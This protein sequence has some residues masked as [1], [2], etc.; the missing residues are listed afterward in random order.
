MNESFE[1]LFF[2]LWPGQQVRQ[3]LSKT[4]AGVTELDGQGRVMNPANLHMTLHFLGNIPVQRVACFIENAQKIE[5]PCFELEINQLGYFDRPKISWLGPVEIP[6]ALLGLHKLLGENIKNCGF[7]AEIRPYRP[8]I[9]MA[10]KVK[11]AVIINPISSIPW[12]V[13][14][15]A[16]VKSIVQGG[17]VQYQVK[18]LFSLEK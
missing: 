8:H 10:R 3:S 17:S 5:S 13:D 7:Q 18:T 14:S 15:F 12:K 4:I 11:Q 2:A 9:T 16:L 1:R 6:T